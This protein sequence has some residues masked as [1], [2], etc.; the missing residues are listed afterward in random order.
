MH[1][2]QVNILVECNNFIMSVCVYV[3][4]Y[5][6]EEGKNSCDFVAMNY[7]LEAIKSLYVHFQIQSFCKH[8]GLFIFKIKQNPPQVVSL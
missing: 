6:R 4:V 8:M 5:K 2:F 3:F 1:G 7:S